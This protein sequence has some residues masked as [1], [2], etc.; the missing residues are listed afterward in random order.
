MERSLFGDMGKTPG[1]GARLVLLAVA[2]LQ[3]TDLEGSVSSSLAG[4]TATF[5]SL[6][7]EQF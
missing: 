3:A 6:V 7:A 2:V 5:P 1:Y 4:K